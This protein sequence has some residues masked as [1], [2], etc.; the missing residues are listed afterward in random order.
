[1]TDVAPARTDLDLTPA[2]DAALTTRCPPSRTPRRRPGA[3]VLFAAH[4][5]AAEVMPGGNTR[6]VL[7]HGP[8]PLRIVRGEGAR[9]GTRTA[10]GTSISSV[11]TP[12]A[13]SATAIR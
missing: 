7:Y 8:F 2:V 10:T 12:Q 3:A 11:S 1:M 5:E 13:C 6:S 4:L 9:S